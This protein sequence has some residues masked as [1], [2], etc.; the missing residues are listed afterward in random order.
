[1][2]DTAVKLTDLPDYISD[3]DAI[4]KQHDQKAVYYAHAG[5]GE[6][7]LRPVL[8][9]KTK[10]GQ[11]ALRAIA[12]DSALLVKRYAGSMS[13]EHGDG[14]V[15][16][17]FIPLMVGEICNDIFKKIKKLFDPQGIFNP[18]KIVD[19][20]PMDKDLRYDAGQPAFS[21][22]TMLRFDNGES[23]QQAAERCNGSGDCRKQAW[24]GATMCPSYQATMN[25]K[26]STRARA[27]ILREVLTHP[28]NPA[29]PLDS[30]EL[31]DV[32]DLCLSCKACKTDCPSSVDMAALKAEAMHHYQR[33]HGVDLRSRFFGTFHKKAALAAPFAR[34]ANFALKRDQVNAL[35]KRKLNIAPQRSIPAFSVRSASSV[36]NAYRNKSASIDFLLYIDEFTQYQDAAIA[37][38]VALF[39]KKLGLKFDVIY[40][41]SGRAAI[42]KGLLREAKKCAEKTLEKLQPYVDRRLPIVGIE[43]SALLGL[44]DEFAKLVDPSKIEKAH[45]L[46][47]AALTFEEYVFQL[48]ETGKLGSDHFTRDEKEIHIHLHCHQKALSHVKFTKAILKLPAGHTVRVIPSGCCGMAGSF[49][50][51]AEHYEVSNQIG[52]LV[53]MPHIRNHPNALIVAAG[54]SCRHQIKDAVAVKAL[55]PAQLL[56]KSLK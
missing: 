19:A 28:E 35:F 54:T 41:P 55:H 42:S 48:M 22:P 5:A 17:E 12:K 36:L 6:L 40:A 23:M 9:L 26:D 52:E 8:N 10:E 49:G 33:R 32:L 1:M 56:L 39:F 13:G 18:G 37:K 30:K 20:A 51:E 11:L 29:Y 50:Y 34:L 27:N 16:G 3:F 53:L 47:K 46:A 43:P 2:E 7:H 38:D 24:T 4:M 25:E 44:R 21:F 14:R 15:R 31:K 45:A